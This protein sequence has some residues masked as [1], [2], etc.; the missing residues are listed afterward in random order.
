MHFDAEAVLC[1]A[2]CA[3]QPIKP[4]LHDQATIS[5]VCLAGRTNLIVNK[6]IHSQ[7]PGLFNGGWMLWWVYCVVRQQ[8]TAMGGKH[9]LSS[10]CKPAVHVSTT[11]ATFDDEDYL[12]AEL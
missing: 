11:Y 12:E 8:C 2:A 6:R 10:C 7:S 1:T 3:P 4:A 9:F 5:A